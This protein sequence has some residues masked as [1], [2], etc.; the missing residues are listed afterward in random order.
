MTKRDKA[1]FDKAFARMEAKG[2]FVK[3]H[4]KAVAKVQA[5][6]TTLRAIQK[7]RRQTTPV[8]VSRAASAG[9]APL[10]AKKK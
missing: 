1:V 9:K 3:L 8:S 5:N 4:T 10:A 6:P 7:P 2:Y